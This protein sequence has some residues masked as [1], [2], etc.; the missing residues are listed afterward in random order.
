MTETKDFE[1]KCNMVEININNN[2]IEK[3]L[4]N[5]KLNN[6]LNEKFDLLFKNSK[7]KNVNKNLCQLEINI[8]QNIKSTLQNRSG[9]IGRVNKQIRVEYSLKGKNINI[10]KAFVIFYGSNVSEY[11]YSDFV[12]NKKEESNNIQNIA[13]KIYFG[14]I[15]S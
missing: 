3:K 13:D 7:I 9:N 8:D 4:F 6:F 11:V 14:I 15:N 1:N 10:N 2:D 5:S 12:K